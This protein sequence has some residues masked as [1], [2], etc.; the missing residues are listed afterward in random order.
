MAIN[1]SFGNND[2]LLVEQAA[3]TLLLHPAVAGAQVTVWI[4]VSV[5]EGSPLNIPH[6]L[7][8]TMSASRGISQASQRLC[9]LAADSLAQPG[10]KGQAVQMSGYISDSQ[11]LAVD[12]LRGGGDVE[13][14]LQV[15]ASRVDPTV[16][17]PRLSRQ[18]G[19]LDVS[20]A[21]SDWLRE[22]RRAQTGTYLELLMPVTGDQTYVTAAKHLIK[23]RNLIREG[24]LDE[25]VVQ[26]RQSLELVRDG[27]G[28][29][30]LP[31]REAEERLRAAKSA[32]AR[33]RTKEQRWLVVA[34]ALYS[35]MSSGAHAGETQEWD[36]AEAEAAVVMAASLLHQRVEHSAPTTSP[37]AAYPLQEEGPS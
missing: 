13:L 5:Q 4:Q 3:R 33:D 10:L 2:V 36:R 25:G 6:E 28:V 22:F 32:A 27:D 11:L 31:R 29:T 7:A 24:H 8:A 34:D 30:L 20:V 1:L 19:Y 26:A 9:T 35:L 14:H 17:A 21:S 12:T 37:A 15:T 23:G 18:T 16:G